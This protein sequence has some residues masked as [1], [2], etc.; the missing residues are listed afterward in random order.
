MAHGRLHILTPL[1]MLAAVLCGS[2]TAETQDAR[3]LDGLRRRGMFTLAESYCQRQLRRDDLS[4]IQQAELVIELSRCF[5]QH[6]VHSPPNSTKRDP[7]WKQAHQVT[8]EFVGTHRNHPRRLLIETQGALSLVVRGELARQEAEV[9][10]NTAQR[11]ELARDQLLRAVVRLKEIEAA[12]AEQS[13]RPPRP[14]QLAA[15]A[16]DRYELL[17]LQ[18]NIN[19]QLARALRNQAFCYPAGSADR[20]NSLNEALVRLKPVAEAVDAN[21]LVWR[22]RVDQIVCLRLQEKYA[23]ATRRMDELAEQQPPTW[24]KLRR[25]AE[26]I[27]I[28][29][30]QRGLT[31]A[32]QLV[33]AGHQI[34][35]Q[36]SAELDSAHLEAYLAAAGAAG[37]AG[38]KDDAQRWQ[39]RA[40]T[41]VRRIESRHG[42]YWTRRA[43]TLMGRLIGS[44]GTGNLRTLEKLALRF[45]HS[46]QIDQAVAAYDRAWR[47]AAAEGNTSEQFK[48]ARTA[49]AIEE[50]RGNLYEARDRSRA[51]A[52][53]LR[54]HADAP[55]THLRAIKLAA[56]LVPQGK[57]DARTIYAALIDE[58]LKAWSDSPTA[59]EAHWRLGW[60]RMAQRD[61]QQ[62]IE[63][64][65]RPKANHPVYTQA[66]IDTARCYRKWIAAT[67]AAGRQS[68][69]LARQAAQHFEQV[70]T[71]PNGKLPEQWSPAAREAGLAAA[72]LWLNETRGGYRQAEQVIAAALAGSPR[73][74]EEWTS[75]MQ[76]LLVFSLAGQGK[77]EAAA[78]TLQKVSAGDPGELLDLL[79]GLSDIAGASTPQVRGQLAAL[80]LDALKL[81]GPQRGALTK[82]QQQQLAHIEAAALAA[83]GK[84]EAAHAA[85]EKL[86]QSFPNDAAVQEAQARFLISSDKPQWIK[87]A[88]AKWHAIQRRSKPASARWF[89]AKYSQALANERLGNKQQAAKIIKLLQVLHPELGGA[90]MKA[91][92][93]ALLKRCQ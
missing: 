32:I 61:W 66:V 22:A 56:A 7:L 83:A 26:L 89:R 17:S 63:A 93:L 60:Q 29:L 19:Y 12:V 8:E 92:F 78:Q 85:Y 21:R 48:L 20:A 59:D 23:T 25:Q 70:I 47:Q 52:M 14:N 37:K 69:P 76:S 53:S 91:K 30:A 27:R 42:P 49:A 44:G 87:E 38:Q 80:Q 64:F 72:G 35:G 54:S 31:R 58:H 18:A 13:T 51:L 4:P 33:D 90:E 3:F 65:K 55:K 43:D 24:V 15:G 36:T 82:P 79:T 67:K 11:L 77:R 1:F 75:K 40:E 88:R 6:A 9:L 16:L 71:G 5:T 28:V 50:K 46:G 74:P 68:E 41:Q 34:D 45:Y 62:A 10:P 57:A 73:A 2:V 39:Q 86:S 84:H 81:L